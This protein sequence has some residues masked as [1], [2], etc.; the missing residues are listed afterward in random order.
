MSFIQSHLYD[1][2][3]YYVKSTIDLSNCA[4]SP[5]TSAVYTMNSGLYL[6]ALTVFAY[7]THNE[8]LIQRYDDLYFAFI[9]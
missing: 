4:S 8:T 9:L 2:T 1:G 3:T 5:S 6:E 7:A